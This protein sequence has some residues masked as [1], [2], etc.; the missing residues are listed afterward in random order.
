[1]E[2][3]SLADGRQAFDI[4]R[5]SGITREVLFFWDPSS[6]LDA[7]RGTF[8]GRMRQLSALEFPLYGLNNTAF[9]IEESL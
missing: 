3:L 9:E 1:M 4:M 5:L 2:Y 8:L 6:A 7:L